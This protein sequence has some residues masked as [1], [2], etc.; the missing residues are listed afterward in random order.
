M[1]LVPENPGSQI[2]PE[3]GLVKNC[4]FI[5]YKHAGK[6]HLYTKNKSLKKKG[7]KLSF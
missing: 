4:T 5:L 3:S 7:L 1:G 6:T 2:P